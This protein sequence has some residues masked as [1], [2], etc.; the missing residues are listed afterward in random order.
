M[1]S[2]IEFIYVIKIQYNF[3]DASYEFILKLRMNKN[4]LRFYSR[5]ITDNNCRF[6]QTEH[7]SRFYQTMSNK[8][9][10]NFNSSSIHKCF[11]EKL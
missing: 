1:N 5:Q 3:R 10:Y 11:E 6:L 7:L 4:L 8:F 2:S 9:S